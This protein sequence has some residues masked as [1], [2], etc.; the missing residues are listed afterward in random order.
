MTCIGR[1]EMMETESCVADS[2]VLDGVVCGIVPTSGGKKKV[3]D[4]SGSGMC[5]EHDCYCS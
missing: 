2:V 4:G 1:M 3:S 5:D